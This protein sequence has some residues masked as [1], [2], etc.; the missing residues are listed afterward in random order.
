MPLQNEI[1]YKHVGH[2]FLIL[3]FLDSLLG[4]PC[5]MLVEGAWKGLRGRSS[6]SPHCPFR[7][8]EPL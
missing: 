5:V 6:L 3:L 1:E 2:T 4:L 8:A 7:A